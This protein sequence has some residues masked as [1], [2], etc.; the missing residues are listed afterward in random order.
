MSHNYPIPAAGA[1]RTLPGTTTGGRTIKDVRIGYETYG[2]LAPGRDNV[3]ATPFRQ[4]APHARMRR[5]PPRPPPRARQRQGKTV[6]YAEI[7]GDGGHLDGVVA[8]GQVA[9]TIRKFLAE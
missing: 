9:E 6:E 2:S 1:I 7:P 3:P 4:E 8:V 5:H